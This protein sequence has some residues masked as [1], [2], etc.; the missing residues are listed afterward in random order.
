MA[1]IDL[2]EESGVTIAVIAGDI[3][4][5]SAPQVQERLLPVFETS[6][7]IILDMAG[8]AFLS[9]AGLRMLL[10]LYRQATARSGKVILAGLA[11][12]IVD[13]MSITGFLGFFTVY[14]TVADALKALRQ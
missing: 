6:S 12:Q 14:P 9:S 5:Q 2:R 4:G 3:D 7:T 1:Q 11:E 8:V 10:L 13:T